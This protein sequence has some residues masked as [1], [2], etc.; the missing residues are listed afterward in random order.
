MH[1][2]GQ[3]LI[4]VLAL[5]GEQ[6]DGVAVGITIPRHLGD[7]LDRLDRQRDRFLRVL[8]DQPRPQRSAVLVTGDKR[9]IETLLEQATSDGTADGPGTQDDEAHTALCHA[10][11]RR[12]RLA[13]QVA[14]ESPPS[15]TTT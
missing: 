5:D 13:P 10:V 4:C 14:M 3:G 6:D 7:A 11:A 2:L 9:D 12:G 8:E 1:E 15:I